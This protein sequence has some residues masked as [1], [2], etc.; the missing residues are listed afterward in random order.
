VH[1]VAG[2][3]VRVLF[4]GVRAAGAYEVPWDGRDEAGEK[5]GSGVYF[6]RVSSAHWTAE[7][8]VALIR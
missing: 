5:V 4:D 6:V 8:K 2:R 7:S 3:L 1:D